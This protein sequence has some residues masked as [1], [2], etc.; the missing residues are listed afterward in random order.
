MNVKRNMEQ[1][2]LLT[3]IENDKNLKKHLGNVKQKKIIFIKNKIIN[4]II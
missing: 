3:I 2:A 1:E 4:L